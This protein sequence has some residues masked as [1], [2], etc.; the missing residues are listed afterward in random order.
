VALQLKL[1]NE[2]VMVD[3]APVHGRSAVSRKSDEEHAKTL[4]RARLAT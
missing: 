1:N 4:A 2:C 3:W